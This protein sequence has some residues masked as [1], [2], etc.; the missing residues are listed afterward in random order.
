MKTRKKNIWEKASGEKEEK[1]RGQKRRELG[2][3]VATSDRATRPPR[4]VQ[5]EAEPGRG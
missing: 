5:L 4:E 2:N 1:L 3:N